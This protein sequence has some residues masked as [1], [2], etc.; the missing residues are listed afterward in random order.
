MKICTWNVNGIRAV[1]KKGFGEWLTETQPEIVCLQE[2]KI[3]EEFQTELLAELGYHHFW[4][5]A[6]KKGYSGVATFTK[7]K[8]L[9]ISKGIGIE[10]FDFE[11]RVLQTDFENY[12][13]LNIYFPSGQRDHARVPFK[14]EFNEAVLDFC[15]KLRAEGKPLVV[16]GDYNIAHQERDLKNYKGNKNTSGFLPIERE[17]LDKFFASGFVDTF[18]EFEQET[19]FYSWWSYMGQSRAKNV[20]WRIDYNCITEDLKPNLKNAF[21]TPQVLG[22]DH[23]PVFL[24]LEF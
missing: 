9:S 2:T 23:C 11:G 1:S 20:G 4:N 19:G 5:F 6:E 14:M 16:S 7:T 18:R 12:T 22:S 15:N 17:W 13:L 10:K 3:N 24:E 8:P 21:I